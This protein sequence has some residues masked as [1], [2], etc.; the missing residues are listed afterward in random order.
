MG[1]Q[2]IGDFLGVAITSQQPV[3]R[4]AL[5][6][7]SS[8]LIYNQETELSSRELNYGQDRDKTQGLTDSDV[9]KVVKTLPGQSEMP[10]RTMQRHSLV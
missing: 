5:F 7:R 6:V 8:G 10:E 9:Y 3:V 2:K 4:F 1:S